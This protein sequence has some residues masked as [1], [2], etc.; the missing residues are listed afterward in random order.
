MKYYSK[1]KKKKKKKKQKHKK[2]KV[3][4]KNGTLLYVNINLKKEIDI[5]QCL[6]EN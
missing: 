6:K 5:L 3:N 2:R 1:K 4:T